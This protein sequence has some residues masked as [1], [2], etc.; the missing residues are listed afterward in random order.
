M[1]AKTKLRLEI[2]LRGKYG[3][4]FSFFLKYVVTFQ[5]LESEALSENINIE[6]AC[7]NKS[8]HN[9]IKHE[10]GKEIEITIISHT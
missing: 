4:F 3:K 8:Y 5:H 9:I 2:K 10:K 7:R 6:R 1:L